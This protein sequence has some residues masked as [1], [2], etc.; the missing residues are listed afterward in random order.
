[1]SRTRRDIRYAIIH[2]RRFRNERATMRTEMR[3]LE[4]LKEHGARY[5]DRVGAR[6]RIKGLPHSWMDVTPSAY[7]EVWRPE[8]WSRHMRIV[9]M[10]ADD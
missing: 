4:A 1:M 2:A 5:R 10:R 6:G 7:R 9:G 8:K 3:A